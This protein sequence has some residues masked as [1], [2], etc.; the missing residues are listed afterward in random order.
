MTIYFNHLVGRSIAFDN[1][2]GPHRHIERSGQHF[3]HGRI[4]F[5]FLGRRADANLE[6]ITQPFC[7]AVTGRPWNYFY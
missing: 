2:Y 4:C 1:V 7:D 6:R 3:Y 5:A